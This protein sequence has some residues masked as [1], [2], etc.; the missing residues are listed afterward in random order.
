AEG[1]SRQ[2]KSDKIHFYHMAL[3]SS[4][5]V[6]NQLLAARD[7]GF[8]SKQQFAALADLSIEVNKLLNGLIK[9]LKA[10]K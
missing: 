9:S 4:T 5:E 2:T 3:G 8:L 6:Q 10:G 7:L 1:F